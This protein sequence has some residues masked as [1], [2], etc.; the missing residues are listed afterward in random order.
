MII[1]QAKQEDYSQVA[2][3]IVQAMEDLAC[4]FV[5]SKNVK[6]AYPLFEHFFQLPANQYSYKHTLV[7][8]SEGIIAGSVTAYD[9]G[10]LPLYRRPFMEYI[11][12]Y[13]D[14]R[15]LTIE[16]ETMPGE[17]YIDTISVSPKFQGQGIGK[18]LLQAAEN[19]A[20]KQGLEKIGLLVDYNNPDAKRLYLALGYKSVGK[21]QLADGI[22]EHLQLQLR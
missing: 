12:K 8:E 21:R 1:R 3:L 15:N 2:P 9:G 4:A 17:L 6:N 11:E 22:Y 14:V 5:N 18:K 20:R 7:F 19:I 16:N 13:Y 10:L